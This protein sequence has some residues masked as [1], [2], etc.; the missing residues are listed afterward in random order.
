MTIFFWWYTSQIRDLIVPVANNLLVSSVLGA[1][2]CDQC[3]KRRSS[4]V[5]HK[6]EE[7]KSRANNMARNHKSLQCDTGIIYAYSQK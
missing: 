6:F 1:I 4:S 5:P 3:D 7:V 2:L